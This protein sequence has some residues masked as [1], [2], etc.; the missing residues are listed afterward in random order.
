MHNGLDSMVKWC[1]NYSSEILSPEV[2]PN[3]KH[4]ILQSWINASSDND[5]DT[6]EDPIMSPEGVHWNPGH[7]C[8]YLEPGNPCEDT[9]GRWL[10]MIQEETLPLARA[11]TR[12]E[13]WFLNIPALMAVGKSTSAVEAPP[14][15]DILLWQPQ[16]ARISVDS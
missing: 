16:L 10:P 7:Q 4:C 2:T 1:G 6:T 15:S 12:P 14:G 5:S 9:A 3:Q 13:P 8:D 11:Q